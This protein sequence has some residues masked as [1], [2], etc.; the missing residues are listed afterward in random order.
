M[1]IREKVTK[2][3]KTGKAYTKHVLMESVRTPKGPRQRTVMPLGKLELP[4]EQWK[5]LAVCLER[6]LS[7]QQHLEQEDPLIEQVALHALSQYRVVQQKRDEKVQRQADQTLLRIDLASLATTDSRSLGAE[8][9]AH[10]AWQQL[11]F[12]R[13]LATLGFSGKE[14]A[15]AQAVVLGRLIEPGSEKSTHE[16]FTQ[17]SALQ[18]MLP[19]NLEGVGK[20]AFYTIGDRLLQWKEP[21]EKALYREEQRRF[22]DGTHIYLYDLTNTYLEGSG[23]ENEDAEFGPSKENR[24][25]CPLVALA[26]V[27]DH[28][29]FPC[30][31]QIYPGNQPEP[32]TLEKVLDRIEEDLPPLMTKP[33]M[34]MDRGIATKENID[35]LKSRE[36]PYAVIQRR[37]AAKDFTEEY[38]HLDTFTQ[39]GT[40][41]EPLYV[42]KVD[43]G[44]AAQVLCYSFR[45]SLKE[46]SM[47]ERQEKRF[48]EKLA[49]IA[50]SVAKG[51]LKRKEKVWHRIGRAWEKYPSVAKY[52]SVS[53]QEKGGDVT[54]LSWELNTQPRQERSTLTGAYVIETTHKDLSAQD[55][56]KLYMTLLQVESA[57]R[58][59]KSDLG[60]RPIYHRKNHRTQAHLF[61]GVLAYHL[62]ITLEHQ[63]RKKGDHRRWSTIGKV[64]ST[65]QRSTV[66]LTDDQGQIHHLRLSGTPEAAHQDIYAALGVSPL[67]KRERT[68]VATRL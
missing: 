18:E 10:H 8:Q 35:L 6:K 30:F 11:G 7:G 26:L 17:R 28:Q 63:L 53:T 14:Q 29:G 55:I 37:Q 9:V 58:C 24:R 50:A 38:L 61:I 60:L 2:H 31:S 68:Y 47:D 44:D 3:K 22:S 36:Y 33:T 56:W 32:E 25:D 64:L 15:L 4:R 12:N 40:P 65:H 34:V 13:T 43:Q 27:V 42:K 67:K 5:A 19:V 46:E 49:G 62:L 48:L 54:S 23:K 16:W 21:I 20:D 41:E 66:I 51:T 59:L 39:I 52:Y 45:R 1:Y 57:F